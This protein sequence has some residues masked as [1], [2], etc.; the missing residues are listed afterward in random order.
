MVPLVNLENLS[1]KF[2]AYKGAEYQSLNFCCDGCG[3]KLKSKSDII[4][5]RINNTYGRYHYHCIF[6]FFSE[7]DKIS[8]TIDLFYNNNKVILEKEK[9]KFTV[10]EL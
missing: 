4:Q 1:I 10:E 3:E 6:R 5:V 8:K 2:V 7:M 9:D